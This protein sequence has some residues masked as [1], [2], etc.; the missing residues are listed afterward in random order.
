MGFNTD[1]TYYFRTMDFAA[2]KLANELEEV[3][4]N[5]QYDY[6]PIQDNVIGV[7]FIPNS[8][9]SIPL[10]FG[11]TKRK[12]YNSEDHIDGLLLYKLLNIILNKKYSF[13]NYTYVHV[14]DVTEWE[15]WGDHWGTN[16]LYS[17]IQ[18]GFE[19]DF[20]EKYYENKVLLSD[21]IDTIT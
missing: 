6:E 2:E 14:R 8:V 5:S 16:Y 12:S 21:Y 20:T 3:L 9:I 1:L 15:D 18:F 19:E 13:H 17:V 7:E 4:D 10:V 11:F